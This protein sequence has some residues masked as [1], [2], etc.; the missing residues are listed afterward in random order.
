[1][2]GRREKIKAKFVTVLEHKALSVEIGMFS[3]MPQ[4]YRECPDNSPLCLAWLDA[5]DASRLLHVAM[6]KLGDMLRKS[7]QITEPGPYEESILTKGEPYHPTPDGWNLAS[8]CVE[9]VRRRARVDIDPDG[10]TGAAPEP[11]G[12]G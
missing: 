1:M 3:Q 5:A 7:A 11:P 6:Q 2:A 4:R 10:R 12:M 8:A 9:L